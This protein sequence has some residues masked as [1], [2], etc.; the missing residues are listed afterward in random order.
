MKKDDSAHMCTFIY[1]YSLQKKYC[2]YCEV[3]L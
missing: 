1:R 3:M 2:R